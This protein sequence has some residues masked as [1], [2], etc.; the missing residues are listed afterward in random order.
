MPTAIT[1]S[2]VDFSANPLVKALP[3]VAGGLA[4]S[5]IGTD[6][7]H[8]QNVIAGQPAYTHGMGAPNYQPGYA[9]FVNGVSSINLGFIQAA[10]A[11]TILAAVRHVTVTGPL[12]SLTGICTATAGSYPNF[13]IVLGTGLV[14]IT[15]TGIAGTTSVANTS[16][17]NW[18][19]L[20]CTSGGGVV[21]NA[22]NLTE[23]LSGV[24]STS[25]NNTLGTQP[26][27]IGSSSVAA[28]SNNQSIDIAFFAMYN[29]VLPKATIDQLYAGVK[30]V[31]AGRGITV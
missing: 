16:Q 7:A 23:A 6:L 2:G 17:D 9:R 18:K 12:G 4:W 8:S 10:G 21:Q 14:Q 15:G 25:G 27:N 5:Y 26:I 3:V 31:L 28:A 13:N 29:S 22:Y 19:M 24:G 30:S 20:G 11:F 1:L